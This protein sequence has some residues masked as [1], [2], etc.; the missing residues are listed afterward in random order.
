VAERYARELAEGRNPSTREAGRSC[1]DALRRLPGRHAH[2]LSAVTT[3]VATIAARTD[4]PRA[5]AH[6]TPA[7]KEI[8]EHYARAVLAG[9]YSGPAKA[10]DGCYRDFCRLVARLNM[11]GGRG[12]GVNVGRTR[13]AVQYQ[14]VKRVRALGRHGQPLVRW[15]QPERRIFDS[16]VRWF[17]EHCVPGRRHP[18]A[19][20]SEGLRD[21]LAE[22]GFSRSLSGCQ[23]RLRKLR[24]RRLGVT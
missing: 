20:A 17:T 2:S 12:P 15:T 22:A 21:E 19:V 6:W 18:M 24:L 13:Q 14:L 23:H 8:I 1:W 10:A 11:D 16:W 7:E 9:K 5:R 4:V 3:R